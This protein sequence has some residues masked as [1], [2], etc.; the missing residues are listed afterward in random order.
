MILGLFYMYVTANY[1]SFPNLQCNFL[2]LSYFLRY[3]PLKSHTL[4]QKL[5]V[6][7]DCLHAVLSVYRF[8]ND[9][10]QVV[11]SISFDRN[12]AQ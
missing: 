2:Y 10:N 3:G 7:D 4:I 8:R 12:K 1:M 11:D 9:R 6:T 5:L